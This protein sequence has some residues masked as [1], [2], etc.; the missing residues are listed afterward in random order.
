MATGAKVA[1]TVAR[2]AQPLV[3]RLGLELVEVE[4]RKE[5]GRWI[6][7]VF[8]DKPGGV[9]LDDCEALSEL[10]GELLDQED[11]IPHAYF[12]EVSSPGV[13]RP[14]KKVDDFKRFVG[15]EIRVSTL[16]PVQ[17]RRR[18]TGE[19]LSADEE[20]IRLRTETGEVTL[21]HRLIAKANLVFRWGESGE[22]NKGIE[23]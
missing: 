15:H 3:E 2:L 12:L 7:R 11:P 5:G 9:T 20:A 6:L 22:G 23:R 13:E 14:L 19:L 8:I 10:L 4:Y 16:T 21:P 17:G 18:F 1:E